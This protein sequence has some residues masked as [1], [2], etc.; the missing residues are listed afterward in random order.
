MTDNIVIFPGAE[1]PCES[2]DDTKRKFTADDALNKCMG[3]FD[4]VIVIGI[5]SERSQ[6]ISTVALD[7]AIYEL[8]RAI[9]ILHRYIDAME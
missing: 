7:D 5:S 8:S 2:G 3:K 6:C 4:E 1:A 9:H